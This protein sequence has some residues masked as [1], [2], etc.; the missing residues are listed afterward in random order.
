MRVIAWLLALFGV[1]VAIALFAGNN[2]GSVTLF[3]PPYR[4]DLSVN[5][6]VLLLVGGFVLLHFALRAIGALF[7]IPQRARRWRAQ[8]RERAMHTAL[9]DA[10][11][12]L[13]AG[14]FIRA[15]KA[16]LSALERERLL[17]ADQQAPA[18]AAQLRVLAHVLGA[19]SAHALQDKAARDQH[20]R[21]ALAPT[22]GREALEAREGAQFRAASWTLEDGDADAALR[23]LSELPQGAA[24]RTQALRIRLKAARLARRLPEALETAR[25]LAKHHA[26]S[27]T[28][29]LSI[30]RGLAL[31]RLN[32]GHDGAQLLQVWQSLEPAERDLPEVAIHAARRLLALR[33]DR[34]QARQWLLPVWERYGELSDS[35]RVKLVLGLR[36]SLIEDEK[37]VPPE[38]APV[39][40]IDAQWLARLEQA[41][42]AR[43][44]DANLQFL[45]G[46]A[47]LQAQLWGKARQSL[48]QAT[49]GLQDAALN[50]QAWRALGQLAEQREDAAA[51]AEAYKKAALAG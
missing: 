28:A 22:E 17:D 45:A 8:Q 31:D 14:R 1:A 36:A 4:V 5:L 47:Y 21:L 46:M 24:R 9:L 37:D 18:H 29:A 20:L 44:R 25:L 40:P 7:D 32:E 15:G 51:A 16:A 11:S 3:W 19:E 39:P 35:Q 41:Q 10:L 30:V 23:L 13:L 6:V 12:H 48:T 43:P 42:Q 49:L 38:G 27:D 50:R 33:G 34:A 2:Q 26:F